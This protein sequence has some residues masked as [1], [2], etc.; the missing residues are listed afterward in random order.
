[1][2][3][4]NAGPSWPGVFVS[5]ICPVSVASD[6]VRLEIGIAGLSQHEAERR[7]ARTAEQAV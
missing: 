2:T 7:I 4:E 3:T 6:F 5:I 1:V